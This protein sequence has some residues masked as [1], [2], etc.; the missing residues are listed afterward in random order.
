ML[1]VL[2]VVG[3]LCPLNFAA[4]DISLLDPRSDGVLTAIFSDAFLLRFPN[5]TT[6][7]DKKAEVLYQILKTDQN[8]TASFTVPNCNDKQASRGY[9]LNKL[10][11]GTSYSVWYKIGDETSSNLTNSTIPVTNFS[12]INDGL[13]ARSGAMVVI[14]VILAV[15]MVVLLAGLI[16][17]MFFSG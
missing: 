11:N 9:L 7:G 10:Q 8:Q 5:C 2:F 16:F 4:L 13:P 6:Y 1:A 3:T 12:Q 17:L 14:T 15:A